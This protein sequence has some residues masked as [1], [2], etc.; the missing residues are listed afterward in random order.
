MFVDQSRLGYR[1]RRDAVG[2][3]EAVVVTPGGEQA[4]PIISSS[5]PAAASRCLSLGMALARFENCGG[6][7]HEIGL[8]LEAFNAL[9]GF[10]TEHGTYMGSSAP[11]VGYTHYYQLDDGRVYAVTEDFN[12]RS[13][14]HDAA[15]EAI[16]RGVH[17][18]FDV[19]LELI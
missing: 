5:D 2:G 15:L 3:V 17:D 12:T 10:H 4:M 18:S 11:D 19:L 9:P 14:A 7:S 13:V 8:I 6:T 1:C 16:D